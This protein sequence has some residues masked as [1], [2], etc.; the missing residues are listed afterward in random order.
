MSYST[1][2][3]GANS[4]KL[5]ATLVLS[6]R[7]RT[8]RRKG[9][10]GAEAS[11]SAGL[12]ER[13]LQPGVL[14][15]HNEEL[16]LR[17]ILWG[18][19][20]RLPGELMANWNRY[21]VAHSSYAYRAIRAAPWWYTGTR[22]GCRSELF[23]LATS[24]GS[25]DILAC[26]RESPSTWTGSKTILTTHHSRSNPFQFRRPLY[27]CP[28]F[29]TQGFQHSAFAPNRTYFNLPFNCKSFIFMKNVNIIV[30]CHLIMTQS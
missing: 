10:H 22:A 3:T 24:A 11:G 20:G 27:L 28:D 18:W 2:N 7:F 6:K 14:P 13:G 9:E 15:A 29:F 1:S 8:F 5:K 19:R 23:P 21:R 26:T 17:R 12:E 25:L 16:Y 4:F 30:F